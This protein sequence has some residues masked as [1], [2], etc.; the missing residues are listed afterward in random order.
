MGWL[1]CVPSTSKSELHQMGPLHTCL[2]MRVCWNVS[3]VKALLPS[4][5]HALM[6]MREKKGGGEEVGW[7]RGEGGGEARGQEARRP[8]AA[9]EY[10]HVNYVFVHICVC[11]CA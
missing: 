7:W 3:L 2:R 8:R 4:R 11:A 10:T 1:R 9:Y 6:C 5:P